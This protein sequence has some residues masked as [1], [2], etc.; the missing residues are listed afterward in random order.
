[1]ISIAPSW[2]WGGAAPALT[3]GGRFV[4]VAR[5]L[6]AVSCAGQLLVSAFLLNYIYHV[7]VIYAEYGASWAAQQKGLAPPPPRDLVSP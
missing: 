2:L 5:A 7:Q 3:T 6:L 4:P 1:M